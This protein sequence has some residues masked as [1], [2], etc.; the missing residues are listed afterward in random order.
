MFEAN[1]FSAGSTGAES[2]GEFILA[3]STSA[4]ELARRPGELGAACQTLTDSGY[5]LVPS[6]AAV[7]GP[8]PILEDAFVE[9]LVGHV[10]S[11]VTDDLDGCYVAL[12]G[13]AV[14]GSDDDPEGTLLAEIR[15]KLGDRPLV[16]SLDLHAQLTQKIVDNVDGVV[17][18]RT[19]PHIDIADTG[20]RA[21][22]LLAE[23]VE[24]RTKPI[25]AM[26]GRP[27][28]TPADTHNS[29][30]DPYRRL[31]RLCQLAE[32]RGALAAGLC[33]TQPW[34][35]IPDLGWRAVVTTDGDGALAA[36][37]AEEIAGEAWNARGELNGGGRLSVEEALAEALTGPVP[38]V[39]SEASDS[40][41]AGALGDSTE[42]LRAA[43][44]HTDRRIY[45]ST[46]DASA[47]AAAFEAGVGTTTTIGVGRGETGAY[48]GP[49]ELNA[50]VERLFDGEYV[51]TSPVCRGLAERPGPT[52]LLRIG[53]VRLVVHTDRTLLTDPVLFEALGLDLATAD[54]VQAKS[55]VSFRAGFAR[56][57]DR[58]IVADGSGPASSRLVTLPFK[59]RPHPLFPFEDAKEISSIL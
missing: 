49:V 30:V 28:I 14:A 48:N 1:S 51:H 10:S 20:A 42:M 16:I 36:Q 2:F 5:E 57:T 8:G 9:E 35:D 38:C 50:T 4:A 17:T 34:L 33:T 56:L 41:N 47:A 43:L 15:R 59:R 29:D 24:G 25:V 26:A 22:R 21:G 6:V 53:E 11:A 46:R 18:Y 44:Q 27:M 32:E 19:S 12:H 3:P 7:C 55:P 31:M 58:M 45:L 37:L 40:T 13:A 52:A 39:V 54:V 23:A